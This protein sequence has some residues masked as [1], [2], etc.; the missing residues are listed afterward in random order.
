MKHI[1]VKIARDQ[2]FRTV[3]LIGLLL[4]TPYLVVIGCED[5]VV[6]YFGAEYVTTI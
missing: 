1:P 2:A 6:T 5:D 3:L 4:Y